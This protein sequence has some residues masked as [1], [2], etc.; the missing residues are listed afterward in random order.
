MDIYQWI[1][2][3]DVRNWAR[4]SCAFTPNEMMSLI[5]ATTT[6]SLEE[7]RA[8]L[9]DVDKIASNRKWIEEYRS[10]DFRD[11]L[12]E[13]EKERVI[14]NFSDKD[15]KKKLKETIC[16]LDNVISPIYK[17]P[18]NDIFQAELFYLGEESYID[19][20]IFET[21]STAKNYLMSELSKISN[22]HGEK[23]KGKYYGEITLWK[24][25][26]AGYRFMCHSYILNSDGKVIFC[27]N[28]QS[29]KNINIDNIACESPY[30][31]RT[32]FQTGDIIEIDAMPFCKPIIGII[33]D[34]VNVG[35]KGWR[36]DCCNQWLI[37]EDNK[38]CRSQP[39]LQ[40]SSWCG[41][42][43]CFD[44]NARFEFQAIRLANFHKAEI[45]KEWM[46]RLSNAIKNKG[47][48]DFLFKTTMDEKKRECLGL[49]K[50]IDLE[51][52]QSI[53]RLE[54]KYLQGNY[55]Y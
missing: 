31:I 53:E 4:E 21:F 1:E 36:D 35:E 3:E 26:K 5:L 49:A 51:R 12:M 45:D 41:N 13:N 47:F 48:F 11:P 27:N 55:V 30:Y 38:I 44:L 33:Y 6:I 46:L 28:I 9:L 10:C 8:L 42:T 20:R 43:I 16:T 40:F 2:S 34:H 14:N 19:P 29:N 22:C 25:E 54:T 32:P 37:Y 52:D 7:K 50:H 15:W 23:E 18:E 39:F 17:N 24:N